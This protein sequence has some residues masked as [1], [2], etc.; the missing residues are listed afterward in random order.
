VTLTIQ[1]QEDELRQLKVTVEVPEE[2]VQNEMRKTVR[3]MGKQVRIPGFRPGK[4]PYQL[5]MSYVGGE[6]AVRQD[7]IQDMVEPVFREMLAQ[8]EV[9]PYATPIVDDVQY[10]PFVMQV[11]IPLRPL[12]VLGDY[13]SER[14][15]IEPVAL[16]DE[17]IDEA[18]E[19]MRQGHAVIEPVE[20]AVAMG[21]LVTVSGK[22][23]LGDDE[24]D[25]IFNEERFE[26]TVDEES[27]FPGTPFVESL[28]GNEAGDEV[29]FDF[30]FSDDHEEEEWRSKE[31][32]FTLTVLDVKTK[33]LPE[34]DDELAKAEGEYET[35]EEL[36]AAT[37]ERLLKQAEEQAKNDF[38][39]SMV[40]SMLDSTEELTYSPAVVEAELDDMMQEFRQRVEQIG[41]SF[42]DYLNM[43]N[44]SE[45]AMRE[46]WEENAVERVER[47]LVMT[48]FI[49]DE[50]LTVEEEEFEAALDEMLSEYPGFNEEDADGESEIDRDAIRQVFR[51]SGSGMILNTILM[52]KVSE[53]YR[54]ILEGAAP[55]LDAEDEEE[56]VEEV[57]VDVAEGDDSA[58]SEADDA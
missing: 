57:E 42:E 13:R 55:D 15:E 40:T 43:Q 5:I 44:G 3:R 53:R 6:E 50:R 7:S 18:I 51:E 54:L 24:E 2:R 56:V 8:I 28:I 27:I 34:L 45:A 30:T 31:A 1:S 35:F 25:M 26:M 4:A 32:H 39:E 36:R 46:D 38:I 23:Y 19:Q 33:Q 58:E 16:A 49:E 14:R 29:K 10:D 48:Q 52:D 41:I 37:A 20:R 12:V 17:A 22:G 11:T 9:E 21:D 47:R